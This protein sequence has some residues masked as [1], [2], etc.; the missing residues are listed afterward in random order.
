[1]CSENE[2]Q[3]VTHTREGEQLKNRK[4]K[5]GLLAAAPA[6]VALL[7]LSGMAEATPADLETERLDSTVTLA[8]N[9][10]EGSCKDGDCKDGDCKD[11]DCKDG[12]CG[13]GDCKGGSLA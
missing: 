12:D 11:G 2:P 7:S 3:S 13:D 10:A 6:A 9:G 8:G 4:S 5:R 1:M